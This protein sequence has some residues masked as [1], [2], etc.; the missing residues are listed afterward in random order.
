MSRTYV[1]PRTGDLIGAF[2]Y[3]GV[4]AHVG[5]LSPGSGHVRRLTDIKGAML[6]QV[7]SLA[8]DPSS[9]TAWYT[10]DNYA[11]RDIMQVDIATGHTPRSC[12]MM[13]ASAASYSIQPTIR[14]GAS[15][16]STAT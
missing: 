3:P 11:Y 14:S 12:C 8:Y 1:D 10:T 13:R 7:T 6:Y 16:T 15:G 9:N 4:I 2:R 5:V